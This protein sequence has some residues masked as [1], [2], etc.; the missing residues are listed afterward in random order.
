MSENPY[1]IALQKIATRSLALTELIDKATG[2]SGSGQ[3]EPARQLYRAWI[4]ANP[5]H[6][7]LYV[8]YFNCSALDG[9]LGDG[10]AQAE[11]LQKAIALNADFIPAYINLGGILERSGAPERALELWTTAVN[12]PLPVSGNAVAYATTALKQIA[13]VHADRQEVERAE[14]AMRQC[15]DIAPQQQDAIE[16]YIAVRLAQC[17]W[18]VV[19]PSERIS[20]KT[21]MDGIHPLSM[22]AYTDDPMLQLASAERYV[23]LSTAD[24][25]AAGKSDRRRAP[26][27]LKSRRMRVGYISSDLRDHAVGYL[28]AEFFELHGKTDVEVFVYYCGPESTSALTLRTKAA[29]EHW[30]DI[31]QLSD[32]E[33]AAK[34]AGDG[35]DILVDVNGHTRDA[36]LGVF[37]RRPAPIQVNWLGYP[38]TMGTPY[39][40]YIVADPW[41]IPE[42]FEKYYSEKVLRL[43]CYQPNDRKREIAALPT[44][45]DAG[46][47]TGAFVYCCFNGTHKIS[48]FTFERWLDILK[49]ASD[50]VLWLL[51]CSAET[52]TRLGDA[53]ERHGVARKRLIFAPKV[54]NANHLARYP[55]ADL[56]LDTVPYGAHT[57]ASD[58]LWTGVPVLTLSGR[59]FASRVCGS[60]VRSAGLP[61]LVCLTPQDYVERAVALAAD[62]PKI[63]AYK[64]ILK[65]KR[66]S[67][68]LFDTDKLVSRLEDLYRTMCEDYRKGLLPRPDLGNLDRYFDVG[69]ELDHE[70]KELLA[71]ADYE[72]LYKTAVAR[73]HS[74]RPIPADDR[75]WTAAD[76]AAAEKASA[77]SDVAP[78][79]VRK[80]QKAP[81]A[82]QRLTG[83]R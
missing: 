73:R 16:Q 11:A 22:A 53:A 44:R 57:T 58:A 74:S 19:V 69:A 20:R 82:K 63:A 64:A 83:T 66:G 75:L 81:R 56:F 60:L 31:R 40:H 6:P 35:I 28:M 26:I 62:R 55:L 17:K 34:I 4:N 78:E 59:S 27:D 37:A 70:T 71:V 30:V 18:P 1:L 68:T 32:D 14:A 79:P 42:G 65:Q 76:I 8:A 39:H 33:A 38:G 49:R 67:S 23:R 41:I 29:V 61:E 72:G 2:L 25:P 7:L 15:L 52:K 9:Q 47:P 24:G 21:L 13:R 48:R 50:S 46:L 36:R 5:E 43:P 10:Q 3:T 45:Q 12:R 80:P 77:T 54:K 51:D